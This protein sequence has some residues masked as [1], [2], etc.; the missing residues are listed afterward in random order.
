MNTSR[1]TN[2]VSSQSTV[3]PTR[4]TTMPLDNLHS[5]HA[6][7]VD[8]M[9]I[10]EEDE[11]NQT[12]IANVMRGG[13][14]SN[15]NSWRRNTIKR[16]GSLGDIVNDYNSWNEKQSSRHERKLS[17]GLNDSFSSNVSSE[18]GTPRGSG[19]ARHHHPRGV[20]FAPV[21]PGYVYN[22]YN[23]ST[24]SNA[25]GY[26]GFITDD[27]HS[28]GG[29]KVTFAFGSASQGKPHSYSAPSS[30]SSGPGAPRS[31]D[32]LAIMSLNSN[33]GDRLLT[34]PHAGG[35]MYPPR[36]RFTVKLPPLS[37]RFL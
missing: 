18:S 25:G 4:H 1:M 13:G 29:S 14:R 35:G 21:R 24:E 17:E 15:R 7:S 33:S 11:D 26:G 8:C 2:K 36:N 6:G 10:Q 22:K 37:K 16:T 28:G 30:S 5:K 32:D 23:R 34:P 27:G 19:M 20:S 3:V 31:K 9:D 12:R